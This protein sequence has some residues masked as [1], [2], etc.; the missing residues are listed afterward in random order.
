MKYSLSEHKGAL[1]L[2]PTTFHDQKGFGTWVTFNP[3]SVSPP[4]ANSPPRPDF[5]N[6]RLTCNKDFLSVGTIK[7]RVGGKSFVLFSGLN[8]RKMVFLTSLRGLKS[9]LSTD[10]VHS[11]C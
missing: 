11:M 9:G 2:P 3:K 1:F 5:H 4:S 7:R 6:V 8:I 10:N